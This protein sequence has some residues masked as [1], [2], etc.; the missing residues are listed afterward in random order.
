MA[1]LVITRWYIYDIP[2]ATHGAGIWIPTFTPFVMTQSC[3]VNIPY[4]EHMGYLLGIQWTD[5]KCKVGVESL[6]LHGKWEFKQQ[7]PADLYVIDSD[8]LA[9]I[10]PIA[11][12]YGNERT[13]I[14]IHRVKPNQ[15]IK[16]L[17]GTP[18]RRIAG[19]G[20]YTSMG[21]ETNLWTQD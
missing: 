10:T 15:L 16:S 3:R 8:L 9:N 18:P 21:F 4:M 12:V 19:C 7:N 5:F 20:S 14:S 13:I 1:M 6:N 17:G 2:Y 11:M